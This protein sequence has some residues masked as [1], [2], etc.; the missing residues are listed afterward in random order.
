VSF[1]ITPKKVFGFFHRRLQC[2]TQ[3][4]KDLHAL[5]NRQIVRQAAFVPLNLV[6]TLAQCSQVAHI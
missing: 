5:M 2:L 3:R 4:K 6:P 1:S